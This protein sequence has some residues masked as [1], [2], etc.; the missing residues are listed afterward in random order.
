MLRVSDLSVYAVVVSQLKHVDSAP[1]QR[2]H[3]C[4]LLTAALQQV[5][6]TLTEL[7]L[8]VNIYSEA[9]RPVEFLD[10]LQ[11][12]SSQLAL[13]EF[14]RLRILK[15]PITTLLGWSPDEPRPLAE[16]V[17]AGLTHLCLTEDLASHGSYKWVEKF[18]IKEL[19]AFLAVWR[20]ATPSLQAVE[21]WLNGSCTRWHEDVEQLRTMCEVA[22]VR[23]SVRW[24][25]G[26]S[27]SSRSSM[28]YQWLGQNWQDKSDT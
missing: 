23:Y 2:W 13:R 7:D 3:D 16:V 22:G 11:P 12:V 17:P 25:W 5:Q 21:F 6:S 24:L 20:S 10:E 9:G 1:D 4:S 15:A 14:P 18:V 27:W 8:S 19:A 28:T 26:S